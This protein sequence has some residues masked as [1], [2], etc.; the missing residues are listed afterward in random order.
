MKFMDYNKQIT[1]EQ[2]MCSN[3]HDF[4]RVSKFILIERI[5]KKNT[6][7]NITVIIDAYKSLYRGKEKIHGEIE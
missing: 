6:L 1:V 4:N 5:V 7:D 3:V 2:N